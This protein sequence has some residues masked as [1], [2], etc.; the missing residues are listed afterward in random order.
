MKNVLLQNIDFDETSENAMS[1]HNKKFKKK[2]NVKCY[3]CGGPHYRNKCPKRGEKT[4]NAECVLYS[5]LATE[6]QKDDEFCID[7]GA[8]KHMTYK[9]MQ[10]ENIKK[11][12][13]G[14]ASSKQRKN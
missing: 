2:K 9:N 7:S 14:S 3:D 6:T 10:M 12:L 4:D 5:A 11:P 1:V 8:S 13:V